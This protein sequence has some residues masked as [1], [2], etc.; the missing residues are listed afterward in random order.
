M[1][2][3]I[4]L[5][6]TISIM[7]LPSLSSMVVY[8]EAP[9][10]IPV[11]EFTAIKT[12]LADAKSYTAYDKGLELIVNSTFTDVSKD[13]YKEDIIRMATLGI[14][15]QY[16]DRK[17]YPGNNAT[18]YDALATLVRLAG[19]EAAVMQ[20]VYAQA[21]GTSSTTA[22]D[23]LMNQE[24]LT[25]AQTLGIVTQDEIVNLNNPVKKEQLAVWVG[26]ALGVAPVFK[27]ETVFSFNDW[28]TV[29]PVYR[30]IIEKVVSDGIVPL[31][32]DGSFGPKDSVK[33]GELARVA[34]AT[35]ESNYTP[36]NIA[37]GYGLV[38]GNKSE[39]VYEDG[40]TITRDTITV[41]NTDGTV[42]NL[43]SETHTKGNKRYDFVTFK[44]G[45]PSD[46]KILKLGDEIEYLLQ[47]DR[48]MYA[49]ALDHDLVL[50]KINA[51]TLA[52]EFSIFHYGTVSEI[53]TKNQAKNG[54][55]V[56]TEIYRVVDVTGDVFD[57]L[58]DEDLYTGLR[59]D[60]VTYKAPGVGGVKLLNTGD[61]IEYLVNPDREVIY[62]K[63][64]PLESK[65]ISGTVREVTPITDTE[66]AT[67][68][69]YGFDDKVYEYPIAP[70]ADLRINQRYTDLSN[71]VY[72]MNVNIKVA[73]GYI[74]NALGESYSGEPGSIPDFGKIRM[75]TVESIY[76]QS[77]NV[78][79][80]NGTYEVVN[81]TSGTVLTKD[82]GVVSLGALKVGDKI[83]AYYNDIYTKDASRI[84]IEAP[85]ILFEVIYKGKIKNVNESKGVLQLIGADGRSNPEY[86][87]N[88]SWTAS[89]KYAIDLNIDDKTSIYKGNQKV[90]IDDLEK[91]Y[92]NYTA[93]A[94]VEKKFGEQRVVKL[95]IATGRENIYSSAVKYADYTLSKFEINTKENFNLTEGTIV[96]RDGKVVPNNKLKTWDTV[97]VVAESPKGAYSDNA[98][99]VKVVT[100]YDNIFDAIRIGAIENVNTNSVTLANYSYYT[101]NGLNDIT[102]EE[103]GY[104]KYFSDTEIVDVTDKDKKK[105]IKPSE[106]YHMSYSRVENKDS[107]YSYYAQGLQYERYYAFM[108]VDQEDEDGGILAMH[109][110]HK[111]LLQGKDI[112]DTLY[113]EKDIATTLEDTF[114]SAR[115]SRGT[116]VSDDTTWNRFEITDSHDWM[117][118]TA[119]W[120]SNTTNIYIE[121]S[122]A[123]VIKNNKVI[124]KD[125][126][127]I[128]D[129]IYVMRINANA[130][131]IFVES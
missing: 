1:K 130:L 80:E 42:T 27:Q 86:I 18:G 119:Q 115:L 87:D 118:Y 39:K 28:E 105:I 43:I 65:T 88:D 126:V 109:L 125:D 12:D 52:D 93:Y 37:S 114:K 4:S 57:I 75:G 66:A 96:I 104:Y 19:N 129:Y 76:K 83:K 117:N 21:G 74:I 116:I 123:I 121:Y 99:V 110:R 8:A 25:E 107:V 68:T 84:E 98:M 36:L 2:R 34:R 63:V 91:N 131:V 49:Q 7:L 11:P 48:V 67:M 78:M 50:E 111:G 72:G 61:V 127:K 51:N 16:G 85:E 70:Y 89:N 103:S 10:D 35:L 30:S 122:D 14:V 58:V 73:N 124:S 112:D 69:I 45:V 33:R 79:L 13:P 24:Y 62:I 100:P 95:S 47:N 46:H 92:A 101:N 82:G 106:F 32:N 44:N 59:D 6:L 41:K 64:A 77:I 53:K 90:K 31:K 15:K 60:I 81:I 9:F 94:V 97:F 55:N 5:I 20:R 120:A 22:V 102:E 17:Y 108:V 113:L 3:L 40:N 38:I 29:N 71:F 56:I 26:R 128:G 54:K 23:L